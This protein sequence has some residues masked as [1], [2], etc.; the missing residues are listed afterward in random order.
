M[1]ASHMMN[2]FLALSFSK[3]NFPFFFSSS[4]L[5][6]GKGVCAYNA[7]TKLMEFWCFFLAWKERK[8]EQ[9]R[10]IATVLWCR[11]Y[12]LTL[13]IFINSN[14][15]VR[16]QAYVYVIAVF[17]HQ[18]RSL[19][20]SFME[21]DWKLPEWLKPSEKI[22]CEKKNYKMIFDSKVSNQRISFIMIAFD[23]KRIPNGAIETNNS[24]AAGFS[25]T[26]WM[27]FAYVENTW[28]YCVFMLVLNSTDLTFNFSLQ[29]K[30]Q[31]PTN[32]PDI[33]V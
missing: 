2:I 26:F 12:Y 10:H 18:H 11:M 6:K 20:H 29:K 9:H 23:K 14:V 27:P 25:F 17:C 22:S 16:T 15:I 3:K 30:Q 28:T 33:R 1:G 13:Y 24:K 19:L 21:N 5:L 32:L 7:S 31:H 4:F 8:K